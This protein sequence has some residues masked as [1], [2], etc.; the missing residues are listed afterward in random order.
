MSIKGD[1]STISTSTKQSLRCNDGGKKMKK[2]LGISLACVV[3]LT[4]ASYGKPAD[5]SSKL[6]KPQFV[7]IG[8]KDAATIGS[9]L[10]STGTYTFVDTA[11]YGET[12]IDGAADPIPATLGGTGTRAFKAVRGVGALGRDWNFNSGI[13]SNFT[14]ATQTPKPVGYHHRMEGWKGLDQTYN[15]LPYYRR[16]NL[17]VINGSFSYYAGISLAESLPLCYAGGAGYGDNWNLTIGKTFNYLVRAASPA[18]Q[19]ATDAEPAFDYLTST[20]T[21]PERARLMTSTSPRTPASI[22][23]APPRTRWSPA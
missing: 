6:D 14:E 10:S 4:A 15:P 8:A 1:T 17:C 16:S 21:P 7:E 5:N 20:S 13:G 9:A 12:V 18:Y 23:R 11:T 2:V 3:A 19:Y 22:R